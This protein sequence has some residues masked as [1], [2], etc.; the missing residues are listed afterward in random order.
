MMACY[1]DSA[2]D[3]VEVSTDTIICWHRSVAIASSLDRRSFFMI[4]H[5]GGSS[6]HSLRDAVHTRQ[7]RSAL[8]RNVFHPCHFVRYLTSAGRVSW[9]DEL[10]LIG[11]MI[12]GQAAAL[13]PIEHVSIYMYKTMN[14][15][16]LDASVGSGLTGKYKYR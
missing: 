4:R 3:D 13:R 9:T 5:A 1:Q 12:L 8:L 11:T 2:N 14:M 7:T 15:R 6:D 16:F 10:P